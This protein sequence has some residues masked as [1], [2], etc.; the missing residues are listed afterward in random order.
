VETEGE[1]A[2]PPTP[3]DRG[4][5]ISRSALWRGGRPPLLC[6][7][8]SC[9]GP[10]ELGSSTAGEMGEGGERGGGGDG[11][12]ETGAGRMVREFVGGVPIRTLRVV[13]V[14]GGVPG[15]LGL[16]GCMPLPRMI[17]AAEAEGPTA[18]EEEASVP[19]AA[20]PV[21]ECGP[22]AGGG[23]ERAP[24]STIG[25]TSAGAAC[26]E[27]DTERRVRRRCCGGSGARA[28]LASGTAVAAACLLSAWRFCG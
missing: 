12:T 28:L 14:S 5:T 26:D 13:E 17:A 23:D 15:C 18:G 16:G 2:P 27:V 9:I 8:G 19:G 1:L 10:A 25:T 4:G 7:A 21:P 6:A 20:V 3:A 24:S 11:V 22:G